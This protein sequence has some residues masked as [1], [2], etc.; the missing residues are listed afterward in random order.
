MS[1]ELVAI[2]LGFLGTILKAIFDM[3]NVSKRV[4]SLDAGL[5]SVYSQVSNHIPTSIHELRTHVDQRI[6]ELPCA[7]SGSCQK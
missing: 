5:Q 7:K 2:I 6:T 3:R 4:D 1:I